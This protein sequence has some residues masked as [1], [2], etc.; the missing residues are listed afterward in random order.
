MHQIQFLVS[1]RLSVCVLGGV[2]HSLFAAIWR[3][4]LT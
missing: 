2:W 3:R 1:V 4:R